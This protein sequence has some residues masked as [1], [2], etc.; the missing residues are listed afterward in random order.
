MDAIDDPDFAENLIRQVFDLWLTPEI[1]RRRDAGLLPH[2]FD[3]RGAQV[4][5][6]ADAAAP[7]VRLNSEVAVVATFKSTGPVEE[8]QAVSEAEVGD[9]LDL[10]LTTGDSNAAHVTIVRLR[11]T[12]VVAFDFR[13]NASM[14]ADH[15]AS[16]EQFLELARIALGNGWLS[17]CVENL[18]AG[19]ELMAKAFLLSQPIE[20]YQTSKKHGV[21]RAGFN[22][23]GR[24]GAVDPRFPA[25]LNQ[26]EALRPSARYLSK[27]RVLD[28]DDVA[29]CLATAT[30][31]FSAAKEYVPAR[32]RIPPDLTPP[33]LTPPARGT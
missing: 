8:G 3:L 27:N 17:A 12:W 4:I 19:T 30:D 24:Q 6:E 7:G 10:S 15:V 29:T 13:Y 9:L 23:F 2:D 21:V 31:L 26:L 5:F 1:E 22:L 18:W 16:A 33:D 14:M 25:L 32:K 11:D 28:R 20:K